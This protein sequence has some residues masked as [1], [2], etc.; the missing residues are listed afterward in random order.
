[1]KSTHYILSIIVLLF[2]GC[3]LITDYKLDTNPDYLKE[4]SLIQ[5]LEEGKESTLTMYLEA[6]KYAGLEEQISTGNRT[7]IIPT[8]ETD[9]S[10]KGISDSGE[11]IFLTRKEG[12]S[13][14]FLLY[15]NDSKEI[16][17]QSIAVIRQDYLFK[18]GVAHVVGQLPLYIKKVKETDPIPDDVDHS[19]APTYNLP[20]TEDANVYHGAANT[21]YNGSNRLN[22]L[23]NRASRYRY[24]FFK[25][26]LSEVD[27]IDN[28]FS[29]KLCF[30]VKRIVGSFI[31]SCAVYATSNE[32]TE[33]T[34]TY[35]NRPEFG[36]EVSIFDLST[37]WNETDITQYIQNAYNN[38]ETE[39]SFGLK[40]LNGEAI[41]TSQVEIYPRETSSTNLNNS[42][43]AAYIKLQG[44]IDSELQLDHNQ[45]IKGSAGSIITLTKVHLQMSAGPNAQYTY[46]DNNII[47]II[48]HLPANGTL[49]RNGLPMTKSARFTQA[50]LAA[51]IVKYIHNGQGTTDTF[52]LKVQD[53]TGGV[54]T[55]RIP[56]Q[57]TIQ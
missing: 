30:N 29:A 51:G 7:R 21:N 34:L 42:P 43:N 17:G 27:F 5:Y 20:V 1:M 15:V 46:N 38:S 12:A 57:I 32:W 9:Q 39:V 25:F 49:V 35:N 26:A 44:A 28:L 33:K 53:Y 47:F 48:E 37:A 24:T 6:I 41:S 16:D 52:I 2:S 36:L 40:V 31:P 11:P 19:Q 14:K 55:E 8:N 45:Q 3:N 54:Y 4:V 23:C 56:M 50:E 13:D 22:Y 10:V 18:D